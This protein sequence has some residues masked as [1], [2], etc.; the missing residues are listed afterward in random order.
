MARTRAARSDG[1]VRHIACPPFDTVVDGNL[2]DR[3]QRFV[4]KSRDTESRAQFFVE[5]AKI[6]QVRSQ[7]G[8]L[9]SIVGEQK[10]LESGVPQTGKLALHHNRRQHGELKFGIGALAELRATTVFFHANDAA[11]AAY[12]KTE[13]REGFNRFW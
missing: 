9:Q 1:F 7:R 8:E 3:A 11:R 13:G 2:T 10:F 5:F 4:V 12:G 6:L